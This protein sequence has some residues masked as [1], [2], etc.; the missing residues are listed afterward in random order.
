MSTDEPDTARIVERTREQYSRGVE[1]SDIVVALHR[2][3]VGLLDSIKIVRLACGIALGAAKQAV[4][5][6]EV[7]SEEVERNQPLHDAAEAAEDEEKV[8][9]SDS[10]E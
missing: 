9:S 4:T 8:P 3:G 7:W 1:L 10:S 5:S 6:N 2:D